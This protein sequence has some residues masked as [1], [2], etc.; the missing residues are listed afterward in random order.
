MSQS[1]PERATVSQSEPERE[2]E[3]ARERDRAESRQGVNVLFC[4]QSESGWS[5]ILNSNPELKAIVAACE[6][7]IPFLLIILVRAGRLSSDED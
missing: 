4:F 2:P 3:R 6:K 1:E 7:Y 5:A